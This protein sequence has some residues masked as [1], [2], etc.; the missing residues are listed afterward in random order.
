ME[1][2]VFDYNTYTYVVSAGYPKP[3]NQELPAP[4]PPQTNAAT[5][6]GDVVYLLHGSQMYS[7]TIS[8]TSPTYSYTFISQFDYTVNHANNPFSAQPGSP[9]T[10]APTGVTAMST[11]FYGE[12][13]IAIA[14]RQLYRY[15]AS[16]GHWELKGDMT[17]PC[18]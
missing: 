10:S 6:I 7:Y 18:D 13:T 4:S 9:L 17:W 8:G 3:I 12:V 2:H 15:T 1:L 14:T 5:I 16:T 11:D